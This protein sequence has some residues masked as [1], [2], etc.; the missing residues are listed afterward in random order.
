MEADDLGGQGCKRMRPKLHL[1]AL[2]HAFRSLE[3]HWCHHYDGIVRHLEDCAVHVRVTSIYSRVA[4][5]RFK[6]VDILE[7]AQ[8][9][10]NLKL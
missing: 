4:T 1:P 7:V 6:L 5:S 9:S 2:G 3:S 10:F 8:A